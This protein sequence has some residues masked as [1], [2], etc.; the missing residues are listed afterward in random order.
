MLDILGL[1]AFIF[2]IVSMH[3][4]NIVKLRLWGALSGACFLL[5]FL[6][7]GGMLINVIGQLGL[8]IYGLYKAHREI[9][10]A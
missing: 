10:E 1:L 6:L 5:Q 3:Q 7:I 8:V 2:L 4:E 9:K